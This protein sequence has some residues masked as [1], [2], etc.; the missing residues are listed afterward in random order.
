MPV[1]D[2]DKVLLSREALK[3]PQGLDLKSVKNWPEYAIWG[4][5]LHQEQLP[6][7]TLV[8]FIQICADKHRRFSS[9]LPNPIFDAC[10][11]TRAVDPIHEE[12]PYEIRA[13]MLLRHLVFRDE[14]IDRIRKDRGPMADDSAMWASWLQKTKGDIAHYIPDGYVDR[15][16]H[17]I[18]PE[19]EKFATAVELLRGAE[20]DSGRRGRMTSRHLLPLGPAMLFADGE[21]GKDGQLQ[22]DRR[23]MRRTGELVWLMVNRSAMRDTLGAIIERRFFRSNDVLNRTASHLATEDGTVQDGGRATCRCIG[24]LPMARMQVYED[25]ARDLTQVLGMNSLH[26]SIC[27]EAAM[28]LLGF[29]LIRYMLQRAVDVAGEAAH[30]PFL[31]DIVGTSSPHIVRRSKEHFLAHRQLPDRAVEQFFADFEALDEWQSLSTKKL[32]MGAAQ[33]LIL[34]KLGYKGGLD[35]IHVQLSAARQ[36]AV[37]SALS[38]IG[39]ILPAYGS[40]IGLLTARRGVGTWYGPNDQFLEALV[41]ANVTSPMEFHRFMRL[42]FDRYRIV[43][44]RHEALDPLAYGSVPAPVQDLERNQTRLEERLRMLGLLERKSDA[45]AFVV[46]PYTTEHANV[47]A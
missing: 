40:R 5:A 21:L 33:E 31:L 19:F 46:N 27:L 24:Y 30:S 14:E 16:R 9:A 42:L 17:A 22:Y 34:E 7:F 43:I 6:W 4:L 20:V 26:L 32:P 12:F 39:A 35:E 29:H 36:S 38:S 41:L 2:K 25:L 10:P 3:L 28:R 15:V 37:N 44:G 11:A 47:A 8:E 45:I 18:G 23:F 13:N 1:R